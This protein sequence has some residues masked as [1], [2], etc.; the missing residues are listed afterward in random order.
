MGFPAEFL[1]GGASAANQNEG[2]YNE[3][4]KGLSIQDVMP[5]GVKGYVTDAPTEDNLKLIGTDFYH[6]YKQDISLL[7]E[8]NIKVYRFSIAWTRI[9]PTGIE[10]APN[11]EGLKFYDNLIDE[12]IKHGIEPLIT[13]SH[14][15]T[16]LYLAKKYDGWR[17][18]K[19]IEHY[20]KFVKVCLRRYHTK[21]K[22][23]LTFNEINIS[24]MSPLLAAGVLTDKK[25]IS[26]SERY[27]IAH[28]MLV[29]SAMVT[30]LAHDIH[31][32]LKIGCMVAASAKYP[33]TCNPM[34]VRE[35]EMQKQ[36][37]DFFTHI[38]CKG[39]YPYYAKRLFKKYDVKLDTIDSDFDIL[40]NTVDFISFSYYNSKTVALDE[41][42]YE[43]SEGNLLRGLKNPYVEYSEYGYP[44]D[45]TGLYLTLHEYYDKYQLPLF[46]AEN[47]LGQKDV[48]EIDEDGNP[49][50]DD[51]YRI[52][53]LKEHLSAIRL[54]V[55]DG[56]DVFGY[57][58]WGIIDLVSAASAEME[59]R[60]GLVYVDRDNDGQGTLARTRKKSFFWFKKVI[61]TN[62]TD[63]EK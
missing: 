25:K 46:V 27:Q 61:S 42:K 49:T 58:M 39:E 59:K 13:L 32:Q 31:P 18:R 17:N 63:L 37:V 56:V 22:Y 30:K 10:V 55:D 47:G 48:I 12:C 57:T 51:Q 23:W 5:R 4:G 35:A 54:A 2:A 33:M 36:E 45:P 11:E 15:E 1:W 38:H 62:G 44:I 19:I 34:D 53:F 14:Y 26:M 50:I 7:A 16:P 24:L 6:K 28:H 20:Y 52:D 40:K 8:L 21:V 29:A 41:T 60:Y 3:G 9:F 43:Q